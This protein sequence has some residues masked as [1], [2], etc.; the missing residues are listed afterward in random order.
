MSRTD[1]SVFRLT[2]RTIPVC[3][4]LAVARTDFRCA[5][6]KSYLFEVLARARVTQHSYFNFGEIDMQQDTGPV[7]LT[8]INGGVSRG[9]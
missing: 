7:Y 8:A 3:N 2:R 1:G 9:F 4:R 6:L 5:A